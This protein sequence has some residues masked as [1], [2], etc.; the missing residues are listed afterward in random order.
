MGSP[1]SGRHVEWQPRESEWTTEIPHGVLSFGDREG[2]AAG[3]NSFAS[4]AQEAETEAAPGQWHTN[5]VTL[6]GL[7]MRHAIQLTKAIHHHVVYSCGHGA[8]T[9]GRQ[10]PHQVRSFLGVAIPKEKVGTLY[11]QSPW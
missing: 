8:E 9:S 11:G 10:Q 3:E 6:P 7:E 1:S 2:L 4:V 5:C